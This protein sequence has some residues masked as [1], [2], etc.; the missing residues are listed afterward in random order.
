MIIRLND[1][2][3]VEKQNEKMKTATNIPLKIFNIY[4]F[5]I[6]ISKIMGL[7]RAGFSLASG[8]SLA[9]VSSA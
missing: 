9:Y 3:K 4:S 1:D 8:W 2:Q 7:L 6:N 5:Y